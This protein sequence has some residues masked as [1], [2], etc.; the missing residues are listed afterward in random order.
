MNRFFKPLA[1]AAAAVAMLAGAS[2]AMAAGTPS[3]T[4]ISNTATVN[5]AVGG[6]TA[7]TLP[8]YLSAGCAGAG[9][10]GELYKPGQPVERTRE[11]AHAFRQAFMEAAR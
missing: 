2:A 10:G 1:L 8:G 4:P 7:D 11:H 6:V 3:G 5:F 9:I